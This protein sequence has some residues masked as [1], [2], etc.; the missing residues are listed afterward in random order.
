MN[1]R[2]YVW[3]PVMDSSHPW[4]IPASCR[5]FP[6]LAQDPQPE[7]GSGYLGVMPL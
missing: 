6:E 7:G 4:R 1:E 2:V 3:C 5:V